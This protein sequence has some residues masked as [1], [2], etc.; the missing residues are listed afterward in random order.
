MPAAQGKVIILVWF[1]YDEYCY[2]PKAVSMCPGEQLNLTCLTTPGVTLLRWDLHFSDRSAPET[3]F[4]LSGGSDESAASTSTLGQTVFRFSRTSVSP[5]ASLIIID[6]VS[7]SVNGTRVECSVAW[8]GGGSV[9]ST[10]TINVFGN[11]MLFIYII[12][13]CMLLLSLV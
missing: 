7:D 2:P 1:Y 9:L 12:Y 8:P 5:L 13:V 10:T 4:I 3:R 6:N 11:R